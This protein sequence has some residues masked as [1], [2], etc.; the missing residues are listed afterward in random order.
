[1]RQVNMQFIIARENFAEAQKA[2]HAELV[3]K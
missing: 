3:E 2:L 1:M